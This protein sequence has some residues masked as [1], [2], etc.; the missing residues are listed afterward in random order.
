MIYIGKVWLKEPMQMTKIADRLN[1]EDII[2]HKTE[3]I[4]GTMKWRGGN[5]LVLL[6]LSW[7]DTNNAEKIRIFVHHLED[8]ETDEFFKLVMERFKG[9]VIEV[10]ISPQEIIKKTKRE[11]GELNDEDR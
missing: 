9:I 1:L 5:V 10:S 11:I 8:T 7:G 2:L 3:D 6:H 4:T